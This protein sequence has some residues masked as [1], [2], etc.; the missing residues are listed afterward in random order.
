MSGGQGEV[1]SEQLES[2]LK[3]HRE[4][5]KIR[6]ENLKGLSD[7]ELHILINKIVTGSTHIKAIVYQL[8]KDSI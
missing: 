7:E 1:M 4:T 3:E 5:G 8:M 6:K 2:L